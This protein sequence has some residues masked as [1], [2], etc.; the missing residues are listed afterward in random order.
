MS[1]LAKIS[2][3]QRLT[4]RSRYIVEP[5][6]Q[7]TSLTFLNINSSYTDTREFS[8][9]TNLTE[10]YAQ[11]S[12]VFGSDIRY[13]TGLRVLDIDGPIDSEDVA[14]LCSLTELSLCSSVS[15]ELLNNL[16][17]LRKLSLCE[18]DIVEVEENILFTH[19]EQLEL[20]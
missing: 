7:L 9:L 17:S 13:L 14:L 16:P 6:E 2:S 18:G 4:L 3:L 1:E 5:V 19:L 20:C 15:A 12:E 11:D 10:L 8:M